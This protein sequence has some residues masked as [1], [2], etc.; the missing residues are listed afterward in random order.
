M[1]ASTGPAS[2]NYVRREYSSG[3]P[4]LGDRI[5]GERVVGEGV[6]GERQTVIGGGTSN[7]R[8]INNRVVFEGAPGDR[9]A[10][11]REVQYVIKD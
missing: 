10:G 3:R 1:T 5:I 7:E 2:Y 8:I 6:T 4:V 11:Q 9:I